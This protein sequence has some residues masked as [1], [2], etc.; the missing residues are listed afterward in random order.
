MTLQSNIKEIASTNGLDSAFVQCLVCGHIVRSDRAC[1]FPTMLKWCPLAKEVGT[2]VTLMTERTKYRFDVE[3][4]N[5]GM[6]YATSPDVK[7]LLVARTG[8][9]CREGPAARS[10]W[11][12][13]HTAPTILTPPSLDAERH[14][15]RLQHSV[16]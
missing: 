13:Q 11:L 16:R 8:Q 3:L 9:Y 1:P 15:E 2:K 14:P 4:G 5:R 6:W 10:A 7:G 12:K